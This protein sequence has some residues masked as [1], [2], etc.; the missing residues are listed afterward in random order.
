VPESPIDELAR[1]QGLSEPSTLE[2]LYG[3]VPD[4]FEDD[5]EYEL[6]LT[7]L[8]ES[9]RCDLSDSYEPTPRGTRAG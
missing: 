5:A 7:W 2:S 9:R 6:F 8:R 3:T 4:L 1:R